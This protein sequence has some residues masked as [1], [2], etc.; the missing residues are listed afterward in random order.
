MTLEE[1]KFKM[2]EQ[3][4]RNQIALLMYMEKRAKVGFS[5]LDY[6]ARDRVDETHQL[7]DSLKESD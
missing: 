1:M 5:G 3:I 6:E 7:F 2:F 4:L